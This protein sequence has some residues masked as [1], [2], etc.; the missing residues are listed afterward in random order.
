M[1]TVFPG[2][3]NRLCNDTFVAYSVTVSEGPWWLVFVKSLFCVSGD[4]SKGTDGTLQVYQ[5]T[6]PLKLDADNSFFPGLFLEI[7]SACFQQHVT[8]EAIYF[9]KHSNL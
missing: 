6:D 1:H 8:L 2:S 4:F 3:L 9:L 5:W 7:D